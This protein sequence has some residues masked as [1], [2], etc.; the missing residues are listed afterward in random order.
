MQQN[1]VAGC[2]KHF[3]GLGAL[4]SDPRMGLPTINRSPSELQRVDLAPYQ[5]MIGKNHPAVIMDTDVL[6]PGIDPTLPAERSP[7]T[8]KDLLRGQVGYDGV[9]ITDG[10]YRPGI[11]ERRMLSWA[12]MLAI[13]AGNDLIEGP[14][15]VSQLAAVVSALKQ[16]LQDGQLTQAQINRSVKRILLMQFEHG[17]IK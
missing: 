17:I 14:Y 13:I 16:A 9:V 10:L 1:R 5:A 3:P 15:A 8:V 12:A 11:S 7:K 6:I 2:L 4:T